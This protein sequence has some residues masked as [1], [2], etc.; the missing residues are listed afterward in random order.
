M[1]KIL[2]LVLGLV[3]GSA[4]FANTNNDSKLSAKTSVVE[5]EKVKLVIAPMNAKARLELMDS[6]GHLLYSSRVNLSHGIKQVFD[7]SH[8]E[9]GLYQLSLSVGDEQTVKTIDI[10]ETTSQQVVTFQ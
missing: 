2:L 7:V 8:L 9:N 1:K 4:S 3:A 6:E 5:N 10:T